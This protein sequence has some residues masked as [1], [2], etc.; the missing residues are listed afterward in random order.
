MA[1]KVDWSYLLSEN[2]DPSLQQQV[3]DLEQTEA[4]KLVHNWIENTFEDQLHLDFEQEC[5]NGRYDAGDETCIYELKTKHP[6]VFGDGPPYDRD[7]SQ[8]RKYLESEDT[9]QEFGILVYINRGELTDVK[10]YL[11]NGTVTRLE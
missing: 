3:N 7:I 10:E 8:V 6:N 5:E 4:G 1:G 2:V 9:T 11:V